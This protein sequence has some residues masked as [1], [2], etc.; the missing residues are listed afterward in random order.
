[1][2]TNHHRAGRTTQRNKFPFRVTNL[3]DSFPVNSNTV[4]AVLIAVMTML[5]ILVLVFFLLLRDSDN[6]SGAAVPPHSGSSSTEN[7]GASDLVVSWV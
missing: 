5:L 2:G 6:G 7:W 3:R 1:L 4:M